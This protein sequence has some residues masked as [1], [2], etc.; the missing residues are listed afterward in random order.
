M[1]EAPI[2]ADAGDGTPLPEKDSTT[3]ELPEPKNEQP[4]PVIKYT[5]PH[6]AMNDRYFIDPSKP[7]PDLDTPSAKAYLAEDTVH[8]NRNLF[9]LI[10]TTDLPTRTNVMASIQNEEIEGLIP[11]AEWGTM[12]WPLSKKK[13]MA[14]IY[15]RP[16]G[17]RI[18]EAIENKSIAINEINLREHILAPLLSGIKSLSSFGH[19]H[20]AIRPSN[21]FFLDE[22]L[23]T[24]ALGD[25]ATSPFGFD[26][27]MMFETIERSMASPGGR[28]EGILADD[29]YALGVTLAVLAVGD[30]HL[31]T[32]SDEELLTLK[33]DHGSYEA[34]CKN[35][36]L[37]KPI[38]ELFQGLL[39]DNAKARW[40]LE[41][42]TGWLE[43]KNQPILKQ[44]PY[45]HSEVPYN[46]GDDD[47][48]STRTLSLYL[49]R[50]PET[51]MQI[52]SD[53][54]LVNWLSKNVKSKNQSNGIVE[55]LKQAALYEDEPQGSDDFIIAKACMILDP[56][57]PISYNGFSFMPDGF[58]SALAFDYLQHGITERPLE[59][60]KLGLPKIWH[61]LQQTVFPKDVDQN[62]KYTALSGYLTLRDPGFGYERCLYECNPT[63]PCQSDMI[64]KDYVCNIKDLLPA[65]DTASGQIPNNTNPIDRHIAAFIAVH[66]DPD[67]QSHLRALA[68]P[69]EETSTMGMLSLLAF[70]QWKLKIDPLY[71]LSSW[72]GGLLS[73]AINT[74]HSR[75]KRREIEKKI[76]SLV[77]NG[78]L[79]ELFDLI[80]NTSDRKSD[81]KG[82]EE[83]TMEYAEAEYE[84]RELRDTENNRQLIADKQGKQTAAVLSIIV[85]MIVTSILMIVKLF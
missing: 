78:S 13:S 38:C 14:L 69:S 37:P 75:S 18:I 32:V 21:I 4:A 71:G 61:S 6:V 39:D 66:F 70:L 11:L 77:R 85:A 84:I 67:I 24:L 49:S 44:N 57:A 25:C 17:G 1:A 9:A 12:E 82:F 33:L 79:P 59:I 46:F 63:M 20:R 54:N 23:Q 72:I 22:S 30:S 15:E 53:G 29:I 40:G 8:I 16:K 10:C 56:Q 2:E 3:E 81:A 48:Y 64:F 65:L 28:G 62:E 41:E 58:S 34:I 42:I 45:G 51:A 74:Y 83:A 76:P 68:N 35:G 27:P 26:Q 5:G 60:L 47:F 7:V 50:N 36:N 55:I 80:E 43:G 19:T 73:P 52:I 31:G